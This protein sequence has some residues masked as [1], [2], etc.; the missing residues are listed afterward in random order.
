IWIEKGDHQYRWDRWLLS[1]PLLG[2]LL[3]KVET[4]RLSRTMASLL[5][6]GLTLLNAVKLSQ[7]VLNN[8]YI[9]QGI[10]QAAQQL[11]QG[12]GLSAPLIEQKLLPELA[13]RMLQVGEESGEIDTMLADV[14][15]VYDREVRESVQRML[16]LVEPILIVGLG[17][18]VAG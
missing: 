3:L 12:R 17:L 14:A 10:E 4:A 8:S 6:N 15:D 7:E 9:A 5:H 13:I 11:K 1:L 16:T 18:V 2:D